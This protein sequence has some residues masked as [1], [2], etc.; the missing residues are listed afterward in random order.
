MLRL[1]VEVLRLLSL[2]ERRLVVLLVVFS[3]ASG[4]LP[5]L[6]TLSVGLLV[7]NIPDVVA[8]GFDSVAGTR[9]VWILVATTGLFALLQ[10]LSPGA[11]SRWS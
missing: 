7:G 6:F 4:V 11:G 3:L 9:M 5:I 1:R 2:A 10:V 8:E